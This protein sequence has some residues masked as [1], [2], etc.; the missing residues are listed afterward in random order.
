MN[1]REKSL[2]QDSNESG[3]LQLKNVKSNGGLTSNKSD[4]LMKAHSHIS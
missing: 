3:F 4:Y 1:Q 2:K